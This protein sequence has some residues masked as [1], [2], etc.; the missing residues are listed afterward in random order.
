[1][2]VPR[3]REPVAGAKGSAPQANGL[4]IVGLSNA[5]SDTSFG[6]V[7]GFDQRRNAQSADLTQENRP[8]PTRGYRAVKRP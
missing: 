7:V 4:H 8:P 1:M 5:R 6:D 2:A 3:R